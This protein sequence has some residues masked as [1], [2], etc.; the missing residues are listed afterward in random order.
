VKIGDTVDATA[1]VAELIKNKQRARLSC[2]CKVGS[3]VD[4][5]GEAI[6]KIPLRPEGSEN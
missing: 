1:E 2:P 3:T 6:V 4:L 5:E